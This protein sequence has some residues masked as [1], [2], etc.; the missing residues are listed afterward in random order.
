[1][2]PR[3]TRKATLLKAH[4]LTC[5]NVPGSPGYPTDR[6][7]QALN[8]SVSNRLVRAIPSG[9]YC[10]ETNCTDAEW[11]SAVWRN[12]IPGAM[13][14]VNFEQDYDSNPPSL[15]GRTSPDICGQGDV[16]LY[17]IL[18]ETVEDIQA[19]VNFAR[20]HNLRLSVKASGHDLLGRSTAKSSL[21]IHTHK[22][23]SIE[24]TDSFH[25]GQVD[26]G[27][28]V[29]VGSGVALNALYNASRVAN[30]ILVSGSA[31]TVVAAGG[32]VQGGGHSPLSPLLGLAADNVLEFNVVTA[33]GAV[34][35][36]NKAENS[37]LF[38][39]MRGGGAGSWGVIVNA[40]FKTFPTF[41]AAQSTLLL[42]ANGSA[43]I[44]AICEAHAK[45]AFD[46]D[47][48]NAGLFIS[49]TQSISDAS[50]Y[51]VG[52]TTVFPKATSQQAN[53][54]LAP[55][56]EDLISAGGVVT[57]N[58]TTIANINQ[59]LIQSDDM[60]GSSGSLGSRLIPESFYRNASV[61][62][63]D[64]CERLANL[65]TFSM[66]ILLFAGGRVAENSHINNAVNPGWRTAKAHFIIAN[67][68]FDEQNLQEVHIAQ[69]RFRKAQLPILHDITG[70]IPA[71]YSNEADLFEE[72]WQSVFYGKNYHRLSSIKARYDPTDLF[73]VR[74]GPTHF[75]NN[76]GLFSQAHSFTINNSQ[77][78]DF[79]V[80]GLG[81]QQLLKSSMPDGFH[82]SAARYPPPRCHLATRKEHIAQITTWALADSEYKEPVLWMRGPFG[83]GKTAVAQS[84]AEALRPIDKL[85][86]TLFF[87]RSNS[88][89][90]DPRRVFPS[91]A[92][93]IATQCEPFCNIIN[94]VIQKDPSFSTK[95]LS[96][97]FEELLVIPLSQIDIAMSGLNERV[98]II[99]GLDEC[100]GTQEQCEIIKIIT[101]SARNRTTPFRWFI[102]SRPEDPIIRTM[103]SPIISPNVYRIEL[104]VSRDID[105]EILI[106]L[107]DEFKK[108]RED[109]KLPESWPSEEALALLV[110]RGAGLWIYV[111]TI[112]RFIN[113][114]NSL[115]PQDQLRVV[116]DFAKDASSKAGL[117][118]PLAEM[119]FF[120]AL[121]MERIPLNIRT[122]IRK[123]LLIHTTKARF[124]MSSITGT[125]CISTEQF[126]RA[127]SFLRSV[128]EL[129]GTRINNMKLHCYHESFL[130][131]LADPKRSKELCTHGSF[132]ID[133]RRELLE[134]L[135]F[136]CSHSTD[137]SH[138]VFPPGTVLPEDLLSG[139]YYGHVVD[140]FWEFFCL[141]H[142]PIDI[143]TAMSISKL[144]FQKVLRLFPTDQQGVSWGI[145]G[146]RIKQFRDNL[147]TEFQERIVRM[148]KCPIS[149]CTNTAHVMILGEGDNEA[150]AFG[151]G[152]Y[153]LSLRNNQEPS[154]APIISFRMAD[155]ERSSPVNLSS[156]STTSD[157]RAATVQQ[158]PVPPPPNLTPP[159][160]RK[161]PPPPP[162]HRNPP[163][164]RPP[165]RL[166]PRTRPQPRLP[167]PIPPRTLPPLPSEP[168][169]LTSRDQDPGQQIPIAPQQNALSQ[170]SRDQNC[171][172]FFS[173][174]QNF[175]INS[176]QFNNFSA[177]GSGFKQLLKHSM[178]DA[179]HDSAA[180]YPPPRCHLGTRKEYIS[181]IVG[182]ARGDSEHK[183]PVLWMRGPFG[184]GKTAVAQSVAEALKSLNKLVATLFFSRSNANR[185]DP[186]RVF[187]SIAF[188]IAIRCKPFGD[189]IDAH[190]RADPSFATKSAS[191]QFEDLLAAPLSQVDVTSSFIDGGAVIID[192]LD[193]CRGTLEQCEIIKIIASSAQNHTTPLRWFITSRPEEPIIRTMNLTSVSSAVSRIELPVSREIDHE[194]LV[195]LTDEFTKIREAHKL[196]ESW[197]SDDALSL[198]VDHGAGV[199]VYVST[200]VRFIND[201][202]S[203]GPED[204]LRI[205]LDF[206]RNTSRKVGP[207]NPLAELDFFYT[208][209]MQRI[210]TNI[211]TMIRKIL[212]VHSTRFN[213]PVETIADNL[214]LSTE[215]FRRSC[216]SIQSVMEL[217]GSSLSTMGLHFY[218][219]SFLDFLTNPDRSHGVCIYGEFLSQTLREVLEW[220][221]ILYSQTEGTTSLNNHYVCLVFTSHLVSE[222]SR[223]VYPSGTINP[224]DVP[225]D[226][227][228]RNALMYFWQLCWTP[229]QPIDIPT[230]R[231]I[232]KLPFQ[233]MLRLLPEDLEWFL[234][235]ERMDFIK[236]NLPTL[237]RNKIIRSGKCPTPGCTNSEDVMML[238]GGNNQA[239]ALGNLSKLILQ[240]NQNPPPGKC[241]CGAR[242]KLEGDQLEG[243]PEPVVDGV[244][245][246][247][248]ASDEDNHGF[249]A[250]ASNFFA[251]SP[252]QTLHS[253]ATS[254]SGAP[255][256]PSHS[257]FVRSPVAPPGP[258]PSTAQLSAVSDPPPD[259]ARSSH[260]LLQKPLQSSPPISLPTTSPLAPS[261]YP[262]VKGYYSSPNPEDLEA[263]T[264]LAAHSGLLST[265][266][267]TE[268]LRPPQ[269]RSPLVLESS[270]SLTP[271]PPPTSSSPS[272]PH[273][274]HFQ[275]NDISIGSSGELFAARKFMQYLTRVSAGLKE[276]L[277]T[278]MPDT[279]HNSAARYPPPRCHHGT[280]KEYI[281]QIG[282]WANGD[283]DHEKRV[284]WMHGP[285]GVGKTAVAQSSA[286][287]LKASNQLI[288]TLFFSRSNINR[289]DPYRVF[290]SIAFQIATQCQSFSNVLEAHIRTDPSFA[291]KSLST[292]FDELLLIPLS[293]IEDQA[294]LKS[295]AGRVIIIDG[296]DE[297]RG[298][299][300]QCENIKIIANSAQKRSTPFRWFIT[301]RPEYPIILTMNA[302]FVSPVVSRLE[303]PVSRDVDHEILLYLTDE[304]SKIRENHSLPESWPSEEV[305]DLLVIRAAGL[306]I[307][308]A[309]IVR[310]IND[311][312]S[313][314]PEDQLRLVLKFANDMSNQVGP[315]NPLAEMD[316]FYVLI[317]QRIPSN[318]RTTIR[319]VLL[320]HSMDIYSPRQIADSLCLSVDQFRRVCVSIQSVMQLR[321][322]LLDYMEFH[323]Y[324]AS[325]LDFMCSPK[326]SKDLCIKGEFLIQYRKE[327]LEWLHVVYSNTT[328]PSQFRFP[329]GTVLP[330]KLGSVD[331]H[332]S[333]LQCFWE[334]CCIPDH[335]IDVPTATSLSRLPFVKMFR[336]LPEDR[337]WAIASHK[338]N[339]LIQNHPTS[340]HDKI[341]RGGKC[342]TP[343]CTNIK[344]VFIFGQGDNEA[345][346][347]RDTETLHLLNNQDTPSGAIQPSRTVTIKLSTTSWY[348]SLEM[349]TLNVKI[350]WAYG[351]ILAMSSKPG[352]AVL[353][354]I[355][356][357]FSQSSKSDASNV[358]PHHS[359]FDQASSS[360]QS[361]PTMTTREPGHIAAHHT[362]LSQHPSSTSLPHT[363]S[364]LALPLG[365]PPPIPVHHMPPTPGSQYPNSTY[366]PTSAGIEPILRPSL[367]PATPLSPPPSM[368]PPRP[369]DHGMFHQA[370]D[371]VF[372]NPQFNDVHLAISGE[373]SFA[374]RMIRYLTQEVAGLKELL[375][376]SMPDTFHN[377]AARYPPPRCHHDTRREYISQISNWALAE[378]NDEQPVLWMHGPFGIGKT[379]VAQSCAEIL[380]A[381]NRLI[382]TLF[383]SRSNINR[384]NPYRVFTSI[385]FQIATQCK[386][387][388]DIIDSII[389]TDPS[390]ATKSLLTQFEELLVNPLSRIDVA[391]N[392]LDGRVVIIDGLDECRG[393][394]EQCEI[395][396]IIATSARK[397]TTPFRWFITSRPEHPII[398][399]MNAAFVSPAV[400]RIELPVSR[401][402][403]HEILIYLTDEFTKI[404]ENNGLPD[405]WPDEEVFDLLVKRAAGLWIYVSTIIRFINDENSFGPQHQLQIVLDFANSMSTHVGA[406]NPLAEMDFFYMLIMQQI[407]SNIRTTVQKALLIYSM[408]IHSSMNGIANSLCLSEE[409]FR[410]AC[411]S[412]QSVMALRGSTLKSM[413]FHFYHA[414]FFDFLINPKRSKELCIKGEFLVRYRRE[415][416]EWLHVV[417]SHTSGPSHF[418][419]PPGTIL[420]KGLRSLDYHAC[421]LCCFWE[422]CCMPDHPIDVPTA[423]SMSQLPFPKMFRLLP[424][425]E[426][427]TVVSYKLNFLI[428]NLPTSFHD[429]IL[430]GEKCPTPGCMNI[431]PVFIFGQGDNEA[432]AFKDTETLYLLNNQDATALLG[433]S[434]LRLEERGSHAARSWNKSLQMLHL[435]L[436]RLYTHPVP[437][438]SDVRDQTRAQRPVP[439]P[440]PPVA[441]MQRLPPPP[442]PPRKKSSLTK[443]P[444]VPPPRPARPT[445]SPTRPPPPLPPRNLPSSE[446]HLSPHTPSQPF[447]HLYTPN[448]SIRFLPNSRAIT[449]NLWR[450]LLPQGLIG[451]KEL[452]D[453][454]MPD[455]FY[456]SSARYPPPRCHLGTRKEY[457][458]LITDWALGNSERKE[459]VLW[460]RG[461]FGVGKSAVSHSCAETLEARNMLAAT[462]FFSR[463]NTN[464]D[465][466]RR[467]FT[468]VAYQIAAL[469][470]PFG[471]I[472]DALVLR[473]PAIAKKSLSKQFEELLVL[474]LR[475][476]DTRSNGLDG[477]VVILDGLD[478]CRGTAEQCEIIKIIS[479]SAKDRTM[480]FRWFITSRPEDPI[481]RT[482]NSPSI[483][484]VISSLE[485]PVS[486]EI[487]HEILLFLTD[488]FAKTR[489]NHG[490]PDSWPSENVLDLLVERGA[491]LWIYVS[492]IVRFINDENSFGP[493]DQ[494]RIV[495]KFAKEVSTQVGPN[496]PLAE[497]DFFYSLIMKQVP[498]NVRETV[499]RILLIY[500][501]PNIDSPRRITNSLRL[502]LTQFRR[503][504]SFLRSVMELRDSDPEHTA[505][506]TIHFYHTSFLDFMKN[507]ERSK[508][509]YPARLVFPP[510][511]VIPDGIQRLDH[512]Q[513]ALF[514]FWELCT[515]PEH[516]LDSSTTLS[517]SRLPFQKMLRMLPSDWGWATECNMIYDNLPIELRDSV[518]RF[519]KCPA[520]GCTR[521]E[522]IW[523]LGQGDNETIPEQFTT[524]TVRWLNN[525]DPPEGECFCGARLEVDD[526]DQGTFIRT[527]SAHSNKEVSWT[528]KSRGLLMKLPASL[529]LA[530]GR[531]E[532]L[533]SR[534]T[535][536]GNSRSTSS[537]TSPGSMIIRRT[538]PARPA[539]T[540]RYQ[541][542]SFPMQ[543]DPGSLFGAFLSLVEEILHPSETRTRPSS[544][545]SSVS[546]SSSQPTFE[547]PSPSLTASSRT[548][549]A[550]SSMTTPHNA[551]PPG[552]QEVPTSS[553][554]LPTLHSP[555]HPPN[556]PMFHQAHSFVINNSQ[557]IDNSRAGQ[558]LEAL[559]NNSMCNTF[560]D[561][562]AR[563]PPPRCQRGT[564]TEYISRVTDWATGRSE[565]HEPV[566]WM[567]GAFGVGKTAVAQSCAEELDKM[568][569]LTA[570][571]F[572]SR[573][574]P[575]SDDP[576]RV[577]ISIAYQLATR[578]ELFGSVIDA[579][580]R[581]DPALATGAK[582]LAKQFEEL[583]VCPIKQLGSIIPDIT[584]RVVILDGLDECRGTTEQCAILDIIAAS[585]RDQTTPFR[586][587]ITSR[588]EEPIIRTM[589]SA[590][591][592][593]VSSHLELPI[594]RKTEHEIMIYLL[595]EFEKTRSHH[596]LPGSWPSQEILS[597]LVEHA[598]GLFI[599]A[600]T[601]I[602]FINDN[603]SYGPEDQ[604]R[605][606]L[607]FATNVTTLVE[608]NNPLAEMDY[609]FSLI[610]Q[611]IPPKLKTAVLRILLIHS[612]GYGVSS[613]A[614]ILHLSVKQMRRLCAFVQS[615]M[616]LQ[617]SRLQSMTIHVHHASF[618][619]YVKDPKRSKDLSIHGNF[620]TKYRQ[621]L[622][623]WLHDV[624]AQSTDSSNL[625]FPEEPDCPGGFDRKKHYCFQLFCF[626]DLCIAPHH[627]LDIPTISSLEKLQFRK[628]LS[629]IGPGHHMPVCVQQL[630]DSLPE[631]SRSAFIR[632]DK[633]P[634][635]GCENPGEVWILGQGDNEAVILGDRNNIFMQNNQNV[636][637]SQYSLALQKI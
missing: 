359:A 53:D 524:S 385:A 214:C 163:H 496:N 448:S 287:M 318:I 571:L 325:F 432:V 395:I 391:K 262:P 143:P 127:C 76:P 536:T 593:S 259:P 97:Q 128:M 582:A 85:I 632:R 210:P 39:A 223:F 213:V 92:F 251:Q 124:D 600:A 231:S 586:W 184:I 217:R 497:M 550:S 145:A 5:R 369:Q 588:P 321:G 225:V 597:I 603:N 272:P 168:M 421:V 630:R 523:I 114:E 179:F 551:P 366:R 510:G 316:F 283:F 305:P 511:T 439:P 502:S 376:N 627:Q 492:T 520:S 431:K 253:T 293:N 533:E 12:E 50:A 241:A 42:T 454:S 52:V 201:E 553:F 456:D 4:A 419:F 591:V 120:Y 487:D 159:R 273:K 508:E 56:Y 8:E 274:S 275:V 459:H 49:L 577:F 468:S 389:R 107:T 549:P 575:D 337:H 263:V 372:H 315:N 268:L 596:S 17:A 194:I 252:D 414:S 430:R 90:D 463:S 1:M 587:F 70:P 599:Y 446:R 476:I 51:T 481:I 41:D 426:K 131:F 93:Q 400:L 619:E 222:P 270:P 68:I 564:R 221:H 403:D 386:A 563:D 326:R 220:F 532:A 562:A 445:P 406:V 206:V 527:M 112:V 58:T 401:E 394:K 242:I 20:R 611:Q 94:A 427:W 37:D 198:I 207:N 498:S 281:G 224:E 295:L 416:L 361:H 499:Q 404:R 166:P 301:S 106:Y 388:S 23:Q 165:P 197:P 547:S 522:D 59:L 581:K 304:F 18:A 265:T 65:G 351:T 629:L 167:P 443:V 338:F 396:R 455:A 16:P 119:D 132:L 130:D 618:L 134:W 505:D 110:E 116:L 35:R 504:C 637:H 164:P 77:F 309:T 579:R 429:K 156:S 82:D 480:P 509:F 185:D 74:T 271:A 457:I 580:I 30:K 75:Y 196:P 79:S 530:S 32:Y 298:T 302:S 626:W 350:C 583:L 238:G 483:S 516:N 115:G 200:I 609:F 362:L 354:L 78:N 320:I 485:L 150:V 471:D 357:T 209:I 45:H 479:A 341:V 188:Q 153:Y 176:S 436:H 622:L 424:E 379:A 69:N 292:Q 602:R 544:P 22:L 129:R 613:I 506:T 297:C 470:A 63:G 229:N 598:A 334:L 543:G 548:I 314:G 288:A 472:I 296:L 46:L 614:I 148:G 514:C 204:Q 243:E 3:P 151:G 368:L 558:G 621:D 146:Y 534:D 193:E 87:S 162:P 515:I 329:S 250:K 526:N 409:Q 215:Q 121:I 48:L 86:A 513:W 371:L 180:R 572:L 303:L 594:T 111:S 195:Y 324:H 356:H 157:T 585:V 381:G 109:H 610:M 352:P 542:C 402:I 501:I 230:A 363:S 254:N 15:C 62:I 323:F 244:G 452:L 34:R 235:G 99:D 538:L 135:H 144:P 493:E 160:N 284:L 365:L 440:P 140:S 382:A 2:L 186:L 428:Q 138:F 517:L 608:G 364:P 108:I 84:V 574:D 377:S 239:I 258:L 491:G 444:P 47:S 384:D 6:Q 133:Y 331:Y 408:K 227:H 607:K 216:A 373:T 249:F 212:L 467:V 451:L 317:M 437:D 540:S 300:E 89:R 183:E 399:T 546:A 422:L 495:L 40:T 255:F 208:L 633:C 435:F 257:S 14:T 340:F 83:I 149:G 233:K 191:T 393:T 343:R 441:R 103:N 154:P 236:E 228:Y 418:V 61:A 322:S 537:L 203:F 411:V 525:Q 307:Y 336:L 387:F 105:H 88:N 71:A 91:I 137:S 420:P 219:A 628:M 276:L 189:I 96:K 484:S 327:I 478:E 398:L 218:H 348:I 125:L 539:N 28:A 413:Q 565:C 578:C 576:R 380:K 460:M 584:E 415:V 117:N 512:Y 617:G 7:W 519:G 560:Y 573:S 374:R 344:P 462:I 367:S 450:I 592:S 123:I 569:K 11:T 161:P 310:F 360:P 438:S 66:T 9:E 248:D 25:I 433:H 507:P 313:L 589:S 567:R 80:V 260:P 26:S 290:T 122:M 370:H 330:E 566:L 390:F 473:N 528:I 24:F 466:P 118:N 434:S 278:S 158:R 529:T 31:A 38:W 332:A 465:D 545:P 489:E 355:S 169:P 240:N 554:T 177:V 500:S 568:G 490:L 141:P 187:T 54:A 521:K 171:Q 570:A 590:I 375:K 192:G 312:N 226:V 319:K 100:R 308:V 170:P 556:L 518:M 378:S 535:P 423:I 482:M 172:G 147:L 333:V 256:P 280:R 555:A 232:A 291:T 36:V 101:T 247:V 211:R 57:S 449:L 503:A 635:P 175:T 458:S 631:G 33:D 181:E 306:W 44:G 173:Q 60:A 442:P 335:P 182:W 328:G 113:D 98:V 541:A 612:L 269:Q 392:G 615:V 27:S 477:C 531:A 561:S 345:V 13:N 486:R 407:P 417:Y 81:L 488:E 285:F 190:I 10:R 279:F 95:S 604:L 67:P 425:D 474:P 261:I 266:S 286:E 397:R 620:L 349:I 447:T 19:G 139:V 494:L 624:C 245:D 410:R 29:T 267:I 634:M 311:E 102:T 55:L 353:R 237:F 72:N 199:W 126:R 601:I 155:D 405:S 202:N 623:Q 205:V 559:L 339:F 636:T 73:I 43:T 347:F 453:Q 606:V 552:L 152:E 294:A 246:V 475:Q 142:H 174:A 616:E 299:K 625:V 595:A 234:P 178:P 136:T 264:G 383:F 21:L 346:A 412:L 464:R 557:F 282:S 358:R 461:P 277:K 605:I 469:C 104:P 64:A 342:P 289:D